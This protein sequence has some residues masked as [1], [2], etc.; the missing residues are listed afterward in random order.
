[1]D[2]CEI[3]RDCRTTIPLS[4][5]STSS[6][7]T[8]SCGFMDLQIN[9]IGCMGC[10]RSSRI[11]SHVTNNPEPFVCGPGQLFFWMPWWVCASTCHTCLCDWGT[12]PCCLCAA[13]L[14]DCE[15]KCWLIWWW[16]ALVG[17]IS[18]MHFN[19]GAMPTIDTNSSCHTEAIGLVWPVMWGSCHAS[20][21]C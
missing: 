14:N 6:L 5:L 17:L 20:D 10:A 4:F 9:K 16:F 13:V 12:P 7:Y 15:V 1:M 8:I 3:F 2:A 21:C 19:S 11:R 18:V